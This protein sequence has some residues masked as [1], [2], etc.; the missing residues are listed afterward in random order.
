MTTVRSIVAGIFLFSLTPIQT[1]AEEKKENQL[2][3]KAK[4]ILEKA[5]KFE[6]FS[7]DPESFGF[8]KKVPGSF[9]GWKILGNTTLEEAKLRKEIV[10]S[11][12]EGISKQKGAPKKCFDPRHG[13][14]ASVDGK[15]VD[16]LICF[17]CG[18]I[19]VYYDQDEQHSEVVHTTGK[20][21]ETFDRILKDAKV[22]LPKPAR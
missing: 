17:E 4:T 10:E 15:S 8:N 2:P 6:L 9:H 7:L 1:V 19:Y 11:L 18:W 13:I 16:I 22:L 12:K 14:R 20:P 3:D 5:E 21:Q